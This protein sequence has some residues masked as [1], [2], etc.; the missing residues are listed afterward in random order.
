MT[1]RRRI[2]RPPRQRSLPTSAYQAFPARRRDNGLIK[3]AIR[4]PRDQ[5][6][7]LNDGASAAAGKLTTP[8]GKGDACRLSARAPC[9]QPTVMQTQAHGAG[10]E[11]EER[12]ADGAHRHE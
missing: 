12:T 9:S 8:A 6:D 1:T 11:H 2:D 4:S 7:T 10:R 5:I 3:V